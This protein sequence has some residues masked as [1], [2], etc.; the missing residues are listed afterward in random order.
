MYVLLYFSPPSPPACQSVDSEFCIGQEPTLPPSAGLSTAA[1]V[2]IIV[3]LL[4]VTIAIGELQA[5]VTAL[6]ANF[7]S[8]D[9]I[10]LETESESMQ[11]EPWTYEL[12][13]KSMHR[14]LH[15]THLS[16]QLD[17]HNQNL[18]PPI[19]AVV[20]ITLVCLWKFKNDIFYH[21]VC[22]CCGGG[23][24]NPS[25]MH[26]LQ[27]ENQRLRHELSQHKISL[28]GSG[29]YSQGQLGEGGRV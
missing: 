20:V 16:L 15:N 24:A 18:I 26:S 9:I 23:G 27:Q 29:R 14:Y 19:R 10:M 21:Y 17:R 28:G 11:K 22:C 12:C 7:Y 5:V 8:C 3:V 13:I 6:E 4:V 25:G 1:V 2:A